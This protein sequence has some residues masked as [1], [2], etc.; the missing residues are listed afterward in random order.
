[1]NDGNIQ[2]DAHAIIIIK[3]SVASLLITLTPPSLL[4]VT[5]SVRET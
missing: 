2:E 3:C 4:P 1:M 5:K